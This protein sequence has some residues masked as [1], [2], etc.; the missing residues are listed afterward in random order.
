MSRGDAAVAIISRLAPTKLN[1]ARVL[2]I[3]KSPDAEIGGHA[4]RGRGGCIGQ[5]VR[6]EL[7]RYISQIVVGYNVVQAI[8]FTAGEIVGAEM[9]DFGLGEVEQISR[10][11][12]AQ[13]VMRQVQMGHD[14]SEVF[15]G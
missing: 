11:R 2:I 12:P 3:G 8:W 10:N 15:E 1:I 14:I 4:G 7:Q 13:L 6:A 9:Q 5:R